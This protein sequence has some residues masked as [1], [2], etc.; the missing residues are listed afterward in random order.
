M[1][2]LGLHL[3][4]GVYGGV[5]LPPNLDEA[6]QWL[7]SN[8][9]SPIE[10][11]T[12]PTVDE[13]VY[14]DVPV[15]A[16]D[17]TQLITCGPQ[18]IHCDDLYVSGWFYANTTAGNTG[19][20]ISRAGGAGNISWRVQVR[21]TDQNLA[22]V[23]SQDGTSLVFTLSKTGFFSKEEWV[24]FE[25]IKIGTDVTFMIK[26]ADATDPA[27]TPAPTTLYNSTANI[28]IGNANSGNLF[29]GSVSNLMYGCY[30]NDII[31]HYPC[32][33]QL[34]YD[35]TDNGNDATS[36]TATLS[37]GDGIRCYLAEYGY[38]ESAGTYIPSLRETVGGAWLDAA[39]NPLGVKGSVQLGTKGPL[40][41]Q[42]APYTIIQT[43]AD[44]TVFGGA[45]FWGDGSTV[46]NAK[47]YT[48]ADTFISGTTGNW[49]KCYGQNTGAAGEKIIAEALS[50]PVTYIPSIQSYNRLIGW[51]GACSTTGGT[52]QLA[53]DANG[54]M[55]IDANGDYAFAG[56]S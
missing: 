24:Y 47:S 51:Q 52:I 33:N 20:V 26:G 36:S 19:V 27:A 53:I 43:D 45:N 17:G 34:P 2:N 29:D 39:G 14:N 18:P 50:Y 28:G 56:G 32:I 40:W 37:T 31:G 9:G 1:L 44:F 16:L 15:L 12:A 23:T 22:L 13:P 3:N 21:A 46:W 41:Q 5:L 55:A 11:L 30:S 4:L 7:Q 49:F 38:T 8:D 35:V 10:I 6:I 25:I 48:D 54:D 42:S